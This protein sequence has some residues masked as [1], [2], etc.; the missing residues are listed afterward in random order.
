VTRAPTYRLPKAAWLLQF[1]DGAIQTIGRHVQRH[2]WSKESVGQLFSRDLT[3]ETVVV[4]KATVL[5]PRWSAWS[6]VSLDTQ[7]A[8]AEREALFELGLHCIGLWHTHPERVPEPSPEDRELAKDHARTAQP[9]LTGLVFA[10][11]GTSPLPAGLR[12]WVA[13]ESTLRSADTIQMPQT[14]DAADSEA[15]KE[16]S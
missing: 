16:D 5:K 6:R 10:I 9:Q 1:S 13:H 4:D 12:V 11:L 3:T 7:R 15:T 2:R 14:A 8:M